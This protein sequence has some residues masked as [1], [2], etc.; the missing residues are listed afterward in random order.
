MPRLARLH[1]ARILIA[2]LI[3]SLPTGLL[4]RTGAPPFLSIPLSLILL[5][6][7]LWL[8]LHRDTDTHSVLPSIARAGIVLIGLF[9]LASGLG[10]SLGAASWL[11]CAVI[12]LIVGGTGQRLLPRRRSPVLREFVALTLILMAVVAARPLS[13]TLSSDAPAHVAAVLDAREAGSLQPPDVFPGAAEGSKDPRFGVAH[14]LYAIL[15]EWTGATAADSLRWSA[16]FFSP[17]W[18]L[19]HALLL[20]RLGMG[21]RTAAA[22]A[23]LFTL[24]AGPGRG[25]GLVAAGFPGS[26]A[27]IC[28]AFGLAMLIEA[29]S[30]RRVLALA[31]VAMSVLIHPF[32]WWSTTVVLGCCGLLTLIQ[33]R[34]RSDARGWLL[35]AAGSS[36][37]GALLLMP[38]ILARGDAA[39]GLHT[40]LVEVVFVGNGLFLAD[41]IW[42]ARWGGTGAILALPALLLLTLM[43]PEWA[44]RREHLVGMAIAAPV[45]LISLN[46]LVAPT[47]WS[48]V[49]Y[50]VVRLGRIVITTW[51]WATLLGEGVRKLRIGGRSAVAGFVLGAL[52]LWGLQ[53]EVS[54]V[55]L[56]LR[57][58]QV[59][60]AAGA[61]THLDELTQAI[62]NTDTDWLLA[63]PRVGYGIRAR[64]G[65]RLVLPPVA[66]ASPNDRGIMQRLATWRQIHDPTLTDDELLGRLTSFG[67]VALL[68]DT[69]GR[70]LH[71]G[72]RPFAYVPDPA[73]SAALDIRLRELAVPVLTSADGWSLFDLRDLDTPMP[74]P[75]SPVSV[76]TEALA[77]G[78]GFVVSSC[79]VST[80]AVRPG[81]IVEI[82]LELDAT[83]ISTLDPERV[84]IRLEGEMP[85]VPRGLAPISKLWRKLVTERSG[86]SARR[87]GQYVVPADLVV[88]PSHWPGGRWS[89][90]VRLR[91]PTWAASGEYT[92]QVTVHDW[93]W[94]ESHDLRDYLQDTDRFSAPPVATILIRD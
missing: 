29:N 53:Q 74:V 88:P 15:G 48:L 65:P 1:P 70:A 68:V 77:R 32:A 26:I 61:D 89:Q 52:G 20:R 60:N 30:R 13:L 10:L 31:L 14:G 6:V 93:T 56:H 80:L 21:R 62:V 90:S 72:L 34:T 38:R 75:P 82:E 42:V 28:C 81:E 40:Q 23:F 94:H 51:I 12:A 11:I 84:F 39:Q 57:Q 73:R 58:P 47:V 22:V 27:Q 36:L 37:A 91:I 25:F 83:G 86:R 63:A 49:S 41:P 16:L 46:P 17:L 67:N 33:S 35:M 9:G 54:T 55:A 18:F 50:L 3:L 5:A 76:E 19:A 59:V 43:V 24:H 45:W 7:P 79:S 8:S 2:I 44:R 78:H 71:D 66:H 4:G 85:E 87:F 69:Q 92:L 64:G